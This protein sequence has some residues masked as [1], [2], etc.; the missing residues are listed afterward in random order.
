MKYR[1]HVKPTTDSETISIFEVLDGI[2]S[3]PKA[4][5]NRTY[6]SLWYLTPM[7]AKPGAR[8]P[9]FAFCPKAVR[10]SNEP[11]GGESI[12][13]ATTKH[14]ILKNKCLNLKRAGKEGIIRFSD[15][16]MEKP[17][18]NRDYIGDLYAKLESD[19]NNVL[20]LKAGDWISI[21]IYK[22]HAT[23]VYKEAYYRKENIAAIEIQ[24]Y[25]AIK[26]DGSGERLDKRI[27][28]WLKVPLHFKRLH[29]P[30]YKSFYKK[31]SPALMNSA[32]ENT[33]EQPARGGNNS[34]GSGISPSL[35]TQR[36]IEHK[37]KSILTPD[38]KVKKTEPGP[39]LLKRILRLLGLEF[40]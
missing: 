12:E 11:A 18:G 10:N 34:T 17:F 31:P 29:N 38:N 23:T 27:A 6:Y 24:Y 4:Y 37:M 8:T 35:T 14:I 39:S 3:D 21:E 19:E 28:G 15:I 32:K 1:A 9:H 25:N 33:E 20:E 16:K 7:Y 2:K 40:S 5:Q 30:Y 26:F 36:V 13:H 22:S